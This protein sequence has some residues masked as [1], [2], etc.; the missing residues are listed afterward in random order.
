MF[1]KTNE[2]R[3]NQNR[4]ENKVYVSRDENE[5]S[6]NCDDFFACFNL[7]KHDDLNE[8]EHETKN[9]QIIERASFQRIHNVLSK[10]KKQYESIREK[11]AL[12]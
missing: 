4:N 1:Q 2:E 12:R 5:R 7:E 3:K 6:F 11:K 9:E 8:E 10:T